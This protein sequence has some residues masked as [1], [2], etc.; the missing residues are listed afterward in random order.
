MDWTSLT[1]N[2]IIGAVFLIV[3]VLFCLIDW[4]ITNRSEWRQR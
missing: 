1:G 3:I 4:Y 2:I